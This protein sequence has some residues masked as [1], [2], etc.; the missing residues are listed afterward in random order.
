MPNKYFA[1]RNHRI[2][3][4]IDTSDR[5]KFPYD[6]EPIDKSLNKYIQEKGFDSW[7]QLDN[8]G[9]LILGGLR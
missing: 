8:H 5:S 3:C 7:I 1:I 4:E 6:F 2:I 9:F